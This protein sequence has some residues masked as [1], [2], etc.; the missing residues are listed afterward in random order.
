MGAQRTYLRSGRYQ[1]IAGWR[2]IADK[3]SGDH[4]HRISVTFSLSLS[5]L[6]VSQAHLRGIRLEAD[7]KASDDH[8]NQAPKVSEGGVTLLS[9]R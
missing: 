7:D 1:L 4:R 6:L 2:L 3:G 9:A 5:H 8:R